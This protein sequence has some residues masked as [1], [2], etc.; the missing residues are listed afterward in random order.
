MIRHKLLTFIAVIAILAIQPLTVFAAPAPDDNEIKA[1]VVIRN[2]IVSGDAL[3]VAHYNINYNVLPTETMGQLFAGAVVSV[4]STDSTTSVTTNTIYAD[5]QQ[6]DSGPGNGFGEGLWAV[7]FEVDPYTAAFAGGGLVKLCN[8]PNPATG[9]GSASRLC[10]TSYDVYDGSDQG[11]LQT[12]QAVILEFGEDLEEVWDTT[13]FPID[14]IEV[15]LSNKKYTLTGEDYVKHA[16][17]NIRDIIPDIFSSSSDNISVHL[18]EQQDTA[19]ETARKSFFD[20]TELDTTDGSGSSLD[21]IGDIIGLDDNPQ[22]VGTLMVLMA[23]AALAFAAIRATGKPEMGLFM[24]ILVLQVGAFMGLV[25]FAITAVLALIGALSLGYI[26]F[27]K[28][29][30]S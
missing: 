2:S 18:D 25:P 15:I 29:S 21:L 14:I 5:I 20:G 6:N 17:P 13:S 19:Y 3:Y 7:Y 8:E 30:T 4:D 26:F 11:D 22:L 10:S 24:V 9:P 27:Y 23:G 1:G 16:I 28:S 12:F